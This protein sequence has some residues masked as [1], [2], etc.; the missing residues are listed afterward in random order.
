MRQWLRRAVAAVAALAVVVFNA[1]LYAP[2]ESD[3]T[4]QLR[5]LQEALR[6]GAAEQMQAH[7]P[8]GYL[9]CQATYGL[10]WLN[11]GR[12]QPDRR[13]EACA[14]ARAA[15]LAMD[16]EVGRR[17]FEASLDP[18][19][20]IFHAGWCARLH[21]GLLALT[22]PPDR[23]PDDL[24]EFEVRCAAI[25]AAFDAADTPF[26]QSYPGQTWPV[27]SVVAI[28]A[29]RLHDRLLPSRYEASI[30]DW[31]DAAEVGLDLTTGLLAHACDPVNGQPLGP[32]RGS[33][34]T[35]LLPFLFEID[36]SL[37]VDHYQRFRRHFVAAPAGLP[38]VREYPRGVRSRGDVDSGPLIFGLSP[39]ASLVAV[40]AARL[41]G[42]RSLLRALVGSQE[43]LLH[44][45]RRHG[46]R[47]FLLGRLPVIDA[48]AA[49]AR[50]AGPVPDPGGALDP[51]FTRLWRLPAHLVSLLLL[52]GLA[53]TERRPAVH[54]R[55][56][57]DSTQEP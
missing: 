18:P 42:D 35:L 41:A 51:G 9:F 37:A 3:V 26:L 45:A 7:F 48:F 15:L 27:D 16:S 31:L 57:T 21:A 25:A 52:L 12:D 23:R 28:A 1:R 32:A 4:P 53:R 44:P 8:E 43:A 34:Q 29:L 13:A 10:A 24:A 20:G 11:L 5:F 33:S 49:W 36:P 38:G 50:S 30:A 40:A 46:G 22:A 17:P 55:P 39:S 6:N 47:A 54:A 56:H 19:Y 2:P 14:N